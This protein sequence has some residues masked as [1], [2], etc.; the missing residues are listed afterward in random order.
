[1]I[2]A[3]SKPEV[4]PRRLGRAYKPMLTVQE[5]TKAFLPVNFKALMST[6][7][8]I[9]ERILATTVEYGAILAYMMQRF[10]YPN[11]SWQPDDAIA[12]YLLTTP[13]P[14]ML[15]L[16]EPHVT[17]VAPLSFTFLLE[18]SRY[19]AIRDYGKRHG[20]DNHLSKNDPLYPVYEDAVTTLEQL[21]VPVRAGVMNINVMGYAGEVDAKPVNSCAV[22]GYP[23]GA[24]GNA[25][26]DEFDKLQV[27]I[28][29]L[30]GGDSKA[31]VVKAIAVL[32]G[33]AATKQTYADAVSTRL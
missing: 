6:P 14:D 2:S 20:A 29:E 18:T 11:Q 19:N 33:Y 5:P 25:T 26:P 7:Y 9:T 31:G 27:L 12:S 24:L 4:R 28:N 30:G 16:I 3:S 21:L 8:D 1:M 23:S 22:A 15:L 13:H 10:G 32:K 17:N